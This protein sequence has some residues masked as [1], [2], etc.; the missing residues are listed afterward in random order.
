V[1]DDFAVRV[2]RTSWELIG[3][4]YGD[5]SSFGILE[6]HA[7]RNRYDP[8]LPC[9]QGLPGDNEIEGD[10]RLDSARLGVAWRHGPAA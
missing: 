10:I 2:H 8:V 3:Q 6:I 4:D 5:L 9:G 7:V 1:E